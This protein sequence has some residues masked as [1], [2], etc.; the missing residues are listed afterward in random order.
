MILADSSVWIDHLRTSNAV[1]EQLLAAEEVLMHPF[2]LGEIACG[3][4]RNR[5]R[6]LTSLG[7]LPAAVAARDTEVFDLIEERRL[8][9]KGV[10]WVDA[11]LL[12]SAL[13]GNCRLWSLDRPLQDAARQAGVA[14]IALVM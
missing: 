6:V 8:W 10:G 2:V 11:H 5:K 9:G 3:T 4:L 7:R 1:L 13:I 14:Y 12:A